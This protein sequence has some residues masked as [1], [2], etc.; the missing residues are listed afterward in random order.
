MYDNECLLLFF[1]YAVIA[2]CPE[3]WSQLLNGKWYYVS[4]D[5]MPY[6]EV[7]TFCNDLGGREAEITSV[8]DYWSVKFYFGEF[9]VHCY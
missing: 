2:N 1:V 5:S 4:T 3:P 9:I 6:E 7:E 8:D